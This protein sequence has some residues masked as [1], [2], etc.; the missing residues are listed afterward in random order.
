M[1]GAGG[2]VVSELRWEW[3]ELSPSQGVN[4]LHTFAIEKRLREKRSVFNMK[5]SIMSFMF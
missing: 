2:W 5:Y 1:S 3:F 4:N